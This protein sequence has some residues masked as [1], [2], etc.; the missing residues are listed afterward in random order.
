MDRLPM[1]A[2]GALQP[3]AAGFAA[4]SDLAGATG[5]GIARSCPLR[6]LADGFRSPGRVGWFAPDFCASELSD[7]SI[8]AA[9]GRITV[10]E[11]AC[12]AITIG[13]HSQPHSLLRYAQGRSA[14]EASGGCE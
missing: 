2:F 12:M 10:P 4:G 6:D 11:I 14:G 1:A 9:R 7:W 8:N 5:A 13:V 3:M